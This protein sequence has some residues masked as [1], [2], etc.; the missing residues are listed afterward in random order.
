MW[1]KLA[2]LEI[3]E[4]PPLP[5]LPVKFSLLHLRSTW[6]S[7]TLLERGPF[8]LFVLILPVLWQLR[9]TSHKCCL[10]AVFTQASVNPC[11]CRT[12]YIDLFFSSQLWSC[13]LN[14]RLTLNTFTSPN[15]IFWLFPFFLSSIFPA[16][17]ASLSVFSNLWLVQIF[18][19][20]SNHF[21]SWNLKAYSFPSF[22]MINSGSMRIR[23]ENDSPFLLRFV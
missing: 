23:S 14:H 21:C 5:I 2:E 12:L 4:C 19:S 17:I 9:L 22:S 16:I 20:R 7:G 11:S 8:Q 3:N 10:C 18:Q 6:I 15:M 1:P 13:R